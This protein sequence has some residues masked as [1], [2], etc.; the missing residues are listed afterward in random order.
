M[1]DESNIIAEAC[2]VYDNL[3]WESYKCL[4]LVLG[5]STGINIDYSSLHTCPSP[6][7][8]P[9]PTNNTIPSQTSELPYT[10]K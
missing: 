1:D 7:I 8:P 6:P 10:G 2:A 9:T 3:T 5:D 4:D